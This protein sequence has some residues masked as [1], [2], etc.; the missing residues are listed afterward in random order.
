MNHSSSLIEPPVTEQGDIEGLNQTKPSANNMNQ[1][2]QICDS[3][4][5]NFHVQSPIKNVTSENDPT[6][7]V[8]TENITDEN[9]TTEND[10]TDENNTTENVTTENV[11]T[12]NVA[13]E[14]VT[15]ENDTTENVTEENDTTENVTAENDTSN[16]DS[17]EALFT[18]KYSTIKIKDEYIET[19][20]QCLDDHYLEGIA[21]PE[22]TM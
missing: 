10:I 21:T 14:N 3:I 4:Q 2:P 11:T 16:K 15:E 19:Y 8:V 12:E 20:D 7:N 18:K 22:G 1:M 17:E 5:D 13:E 6:K 9:N